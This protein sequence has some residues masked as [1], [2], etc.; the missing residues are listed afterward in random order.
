MSIIFHISLL[1]ELQ[2]SGHLVSY[3]HTAPTG[4]AML[5]SDVEL[6]LISAR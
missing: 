4:L 2:K 1:T 6:A 5:T 3:K